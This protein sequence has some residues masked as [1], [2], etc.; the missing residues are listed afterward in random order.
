M[1]YKR[2][3][4]EPVVEEEEYDEYDSGADEYDEEESE[5][6]R[7]IKTTKIEDSPKFKKKI[8]RS[9]ERFGLLVQRERI[10]IADSETDNFVD[11]DATSMVSVL[12]LL[13]DVLNKLDKIEK[14]VT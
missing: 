6:T 9:K 13:V 2:K 7:A 8:K 10:G 11:V 3:T 5:E 4:Q 12:G 14:A 1:A